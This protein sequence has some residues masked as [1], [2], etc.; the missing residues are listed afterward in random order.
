MSYE[1]AMTGVA[2]A[3]VAL[4]AIPVLAVALSM[5]TPGPLYVIV[6]GFG[7]LLVALSGKGI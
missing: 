4:V 6:G 3:G 7:V 2:V 1:N 5:G